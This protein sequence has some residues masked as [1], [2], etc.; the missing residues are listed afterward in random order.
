MDDNYL[1][2]RTDEILR[3][4]IRLGMTG[5]EG[6]I[7]GGVPVGGVP[8]GGRR[9]SRRRIGYGEYS[10]GEELIDV[11][12]GMEPP[13]GIRRRPRASAYGG[14]YTEREKKWARTVERYRRNPP[15]TPKGMKSYEEAQDKLYRSLSKKK[16]LGKVDSRMLKSIKGEHKR[17][18]LR[19]VKRSGSK[20]RVVKGRKPRKDCTRLKRK[21]NQEVCEYRK[22]HPGSSISSARH[23]I[24]ASYPGSASRLRRKEHGRLRCREQKN[25]WLSYLCRYRNTYRNEAKYQGL[26]GQRLL[27]HEAAIAYRNRKHR[28]QFGPGE[29]IEGLGYG[30]A[31]MYSHIY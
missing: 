27:M 14:K 7:V 29:E 6:V 23:A 5:G 15:L 16:N 25:E 30:E 19:K 20:A 3:E 4:R 11:E 8:V 10:P 17:I 18:G 2:Q 31:D 1:R 26:D 24:S 22:S 13:S 28:K 21:Y 12:F 9:R